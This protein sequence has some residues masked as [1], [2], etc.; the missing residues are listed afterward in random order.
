MSDNSKGYWSGMPTNLKGRL[1]GWLI[2]FL[3]A[4]FLFT[5][6]KLLGGF[7]LA[8]PFL[9]AFLVIWLLDHLNL[10]F[11]IIR[12]PSVLS[13]TI[14]WLWGASVYSRAFLCTTGAALIGGLVWI[15]YGDDIRPEPAPP[16]SIAERV[17]KTTGGW[18]DSAKGWLSRD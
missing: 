6:S 3:I 5:Q 10:E 4:L 2:Y 14:S 18:I 13:Y 17:G 16:P 15:A 1:I 12:R 7:L 8:L 11:A 9:W